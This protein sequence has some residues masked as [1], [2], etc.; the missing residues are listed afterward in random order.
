M[1]AD[2]LTSWRAFFSALGDGGH[3]RAVTVLHSMVTAARRSIPI[4]EE[5]LL[6]LSVTVE[7]PDEQHQSALICWHVAGSQEGGVK[8][9][10]LLDDLSTHAAELQ[11]CP[12]GHQEAL[13]LVGFALAAA[14]RGPVPMHWEPHEVGD[15]ALPDS[16]E[17]GLCALSSEETVDA[18]LQ[19][20][21]DVLLYGDVGSGKTTTAMTQASRFAADECKVIWLDLT[22]PHDCDESVALALLN[23]ERRERILLVIDDV[24]ANLSAARG[25]FDLVVQ[26]R[27]NLGIPLVVLATGAPVINEIEP[28]VCSTRLEPVLADGHALVGS[29]LDDQESLDNR[30]D[31]KEQITRLAGGD[32]YLARIALDSWRKRDRVPDRDQLADLVLAQFHA[33]TLRPEA[34]LLLY[35]LACLSACEIPVG[36]QQVTLLPPERTAL[37]ELIDTRLVQLSDESYS[38]RNRSLARLLVVHGPPSTSEATPPRPAAFAYEYLK[39]AGYTRIMAMLDKLD[40]LLFEQ[41]GRKHRS[42]TSLASAWKALGLIGDSLAHRVTQDP[43]WGDEVASAAFAGMALAKLGPRDAW[44]RCAN[45]IR[46][47]WRYDS[48]EELPRWAP[49]DHPSADLKT[50]EEMRDMLERDDA[51]PTGGQQHAHRPIDAE[52]ACRTWMLGLLLCFEALAPEADKQPARIERLSRIAD[53]VI[54]G[55]TCYPREAPGVTAQVI[56]GLCL[57]GRSYQGHQAVRNACDWLS[58]ERSSGGAYQAGG[59]RN[60]VSLS[61]SDALTTALCYLALKLAR[62]PRAEM[63]DLVYRN[64]R[65]EQQDLMRSSNRETELTLV[66]EAR[67]RHQDKWEELAAPTLYLLNWVQ[68]EEWR[69]RDVK[70]TQPGDPVN[71]SAKSPFIAAQLWIIIWITVQKE[72]RNLVAAVLGIDEQAVSET[73]VNGPDQSAAPAHPPQEDRKRARIRQHIE[74][75]LNLLVSGTIGPGSAKETA[76]SEIEYWTVMLNTLNSIETEFNSGAGTQTMT[77]R[78]NAL[79][80]EVFGPK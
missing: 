8:A 34:R 74:E 69:S 7:P 58:Q 18:H 76:K 50:F 68:T 9:R 2:D 52:I 1:P 57:A 37:P 67:L 41:V 14:C 40:L 78:L 39:R 77:R 3:Q 10:L 4:A 59:W 54:A 31:V 33:N 17:P 72:L 56:Q 62:Y 71:A 46:D 55:G 53:H 21:R 49:A 6:D 64:L 70:A 44:Q 20:G 29:I 28:P 13:G 15:T 80:R 23:M 51:R 5:P 32:A 25:I 79:E 12:E 26:L 22:Q 30:D 73:S 35:D 19:N 36:K 42:A 47:R 16:P 24:Q 38:I 27:R 66:V 75:Q 43:T 65:D 45:F 11:A 61:T 63:L 48:D 60:A